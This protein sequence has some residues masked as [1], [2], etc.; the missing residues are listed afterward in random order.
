MDDR[1]MSAP[2][3][4]RY[5]RELIVSLALVLC[6]AGVYGQVA[7][8]EF[9]AVDDPTYVTRN[10]VV[11]QG[12]TLNGVKWA[13]TSFHA[14]NWHPLTWISH[15]LDVEL[16]GMRPGMHHLTSVVFHAIN[17]VLLFLLLRYGTGALWKSAF[18]AALFALHPLHV[19]SVAWVAERKDVLS[20][21]F[22][23]LAMLCYVRY[24][25]GPSLRRYLLV[26]GAFTLG[27]LAK[28]MVVTLPFVLLL[29]DYWPLRRPE[30]AGQARGF[31]EALKIK[32]AGA[33]P[34]VLEKLPLFALTAASCIITY[35][36]QNA[37]GAVST[38]QETSLSDRFLNAFL[39][40]VLY[41]W[42]TVW[43]SGLAVFY[44]LRESISLPLAAC[45]LA[46]ILLVS[47]A[48]VRAARSRLYFITGFLWYLGTL[49]PVIGFVQVGAQSMADRYTY[50]PLVGIF[51]LVAW[52]AADLIDKKTAG[53][54]VLGT[55]AA[56]VLAVLATLSWAQANTWKDSVTLFTHAVSVT[57]NNFLSSN[58]LGCALYEK[59]D[60]R[61]AIRSFK[62]ALRACPAYAV[63][64][65]NLGLS[66]EK[67]GNR[68]A[69]IAHYFTAMK[70]GSS[71]ASSHYVIARG[72]SSL[73][74]MP[75]AIREYRKV[76]Q[77]DPDH[78]PAWNELG[79]ALAS[80]GMPGQGKSCYLKAL[81]INP[82]N[83]DAKAHLKN[84]L[85]KQVET[86]GSEE[87]DFSR[88]ARGSADFKERKANDTLGK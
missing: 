53:K 39:S 83:E 13:F 19:E 64:H 37:G 15:M 42:K 73:G 47:T 33:V 69:A 31:P 59:G 16:Y 46:L 8:F 79:Q 38:L 62:E 87:P 26:A 50:L 86:I 56:T 32:W 57:E 74:C 29:F 20:A 66:Y 60:T 7:T 44:P 23:L 4:R 10:C 51:M 68:N 58:N 9:A 5:S 36:A 63:A 3:L 11:K 55:G 48:A 75:E 49:V 43:P 2:L 81:E 52:G 54:A 27:L 61:G 28:P 70:M 82:C 67:E 84:L 76:L 77:L 25:R 40:Y 22:W 12:L 78:V 30:L 41:L 35:V 21:M 80:Q 72:L 17:A 1:N 34:L 18:V 88:R 45:A 65:A 14:A 6:V 24:A 71:S 85:G